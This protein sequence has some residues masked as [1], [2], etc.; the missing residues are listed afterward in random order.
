MI[1][2]RN[3][4]P[5]EFGREGKLRSWLKR[6]VT[7]AQNDG[8]ASFVG[9]R[10]QVR[11]AVAI[12]VCGCQ[13]IDKGIRGWKIGNQTDRRSSELPPP[14]PVKDRYDITCDDRWAP[15]A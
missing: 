6:T 3:S 2:I 8:N 10:H 11:N 9:G 12:Q 1:E 15:H 14:Q 7:H 4:N 13:G 5:V